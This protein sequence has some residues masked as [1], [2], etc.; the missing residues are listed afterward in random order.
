MISEVFNMDRIA[1]DKAGNI[2]FVGYE[3]DKYYF[4]AQE[5]RWRDYKS[6]LVIRFD[7]NKF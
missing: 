7:E 3:I 4:E 2:D 5:K 6:Q 1:A